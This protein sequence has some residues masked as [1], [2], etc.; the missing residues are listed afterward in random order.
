MMHTTFQM[1]RSDCFSIHLETVQLC[2]SVTNEVQVRKTMKAGHLFLMRIETEQ[3]ERA[4]SLGVLACRASS[5][6]GM[7]HLP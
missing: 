4:C 7:C 5:E 2:Q 1:K 6:S 3:P